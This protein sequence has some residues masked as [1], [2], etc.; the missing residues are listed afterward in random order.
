MPRR[1]RVS[2]RRRELSLR[3]I[4]DEVLPPSGLVRRGPDEVDEQL[5]DDD[6]DFGGGEAV[7]GEHRSHSPRSG[8]GPSAAHD[9]PETR[10]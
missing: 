8:H 2:K 6:V 7:A 3:E 10:S 1:R 4:L 5:V 9:K